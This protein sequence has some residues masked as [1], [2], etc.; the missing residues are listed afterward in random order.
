MS[1]III[2]QTTHRK[3]FWL[4]GYSWYQRSLNSVVQG[5]SSGSKKET[6]GPP[7]GR[8]KQLIRR[9]NCFDKAPKFLNIVNDD[10]FCSCKIL[11]ASS[12]QNAWHD[13]FCSF[14]FLLV[15]PDQT[16]LNNLNKYNTIVNKQLEV[17]Q[18]NWI[19]NRSR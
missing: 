5:F 18:W 19:L 9:T 8:K 14:S 3:V 17:Y 4:A 2:R 13:A 11:D 6:R 10:V 7:W 15:S 12:L 16:E 1:I